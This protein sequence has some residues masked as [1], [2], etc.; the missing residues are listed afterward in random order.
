MEQWS[1]KAPDSLLI[2]QH[3]REAGVAR[4]N[5][6]GRGRHAPG[7]AHKMMSKTPNGRLGEATLPV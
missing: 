5:G 6:R 7:S 2:H 3:H 4:M 1:E